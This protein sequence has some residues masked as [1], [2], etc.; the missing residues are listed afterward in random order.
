MGKKKTLTWF[1][2]SCTFALTLPPCVWLLNKM[3]VCFFLRGTYWSLL[4]FEG[5]KHFAAH[6]FLLVQVF[7]V[8][9]A[10][11]QQQKKKV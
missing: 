6:V 11:V 1:R 9:T 2:I 3:C 10:S 7:L 5:R 8:A 4:R